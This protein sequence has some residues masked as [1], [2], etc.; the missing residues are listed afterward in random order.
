MSSS[1]MPRSSRRFGRT[2][3]LASRDDPPH[4]G[5]TP[6]KLN[7]VSSPKQATLAPGSSAREASGLR[8]RLASRDDPPHRGPTPRKLNGVSSPSKPLSHQAL[9]L[10]KRAGYVAVSLRETIRRT[11]DPLRA[12]AGNGASRMRLTRSVLRA[13]LNMLL[14]RNARR[15]ELHG[16]IHTASGARAETNSKNSPQTTRRQTVTIK[17]LRL[18]SHLAR[19]VLS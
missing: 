10:A 4:R 18:A 3:R 15:F 6:R 7:G 9:P 14:I 12:I 11:A 2:S 5:P 1:E 19:E 17:Q 13:R 16:S 8:S